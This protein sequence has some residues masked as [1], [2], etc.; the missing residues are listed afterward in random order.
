[1]APPSLITR[2]RRGID[3]AVTETRAN[4]PVPG[5]SGSVADEAYFISLK[6]QDY[7]HC[8]IWENGKCVTK[9]DVKAGT[10]YL[11]DLR[12]DPGY[13]I[14]KPSHSLHFNLPRPALDEIARELRAPRM[15]DLACQFNFGHD[16]AVMRHI[17][18]SLLQALHRP[19][20]A[21]QL[22]IDH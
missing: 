2:S 15:G 11:Y 22:F 21:N 20:E 3:L 8:E 19:A 10:T 9:V 1:D 16:D 12:R 4:N 6:L 7:P 13:V 18:A 5:L 14:D 17:G